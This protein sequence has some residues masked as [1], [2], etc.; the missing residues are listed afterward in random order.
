M[1][2]LK[3]KLKSLFDEVDISSIVIFRIF[4]GVIMLWEVWRY[5]DYNWI[6]TYW[7]ETK[8]HF[9]HW[10]FLSLEPLAGDGMYYLF[11]ALGAL[12]I[13]I[14]L[15]LFYRVSIILFFL[16][17][18]Y[19]FLLEQT[20]Y[21]NHFYFVSIVSFIMCFV[22]ASRSISIDALI[23]NNMP[24]PYVSRWHLWLLRFMI[25]L[26]LF[27]GGVAKINPDWLVGEPLGIWLA[28]NGSS[29]K[30]TDESVYC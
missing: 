9:P 2:N 22:P 13:F 18:T 30:S 27:F 12:S 23:F 19:M 3:T 29:V 21:L 11:Y 4:F 26:P 5:F 1:Q 15:G 10:P 24:K 20:R 16:G 8:Y 7:I 28:G 25:A 14:I 6:Y 17:F